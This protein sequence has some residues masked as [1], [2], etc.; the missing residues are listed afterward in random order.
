MSA[1]I[2]MERREILLPG[3]PSPTRLLHVPVR[4]DRRTI[5]TSRRKRESAHMET[6]ETELALR[7]DR[8]QLSRRG[9]IKTEQKT[10]IAI[11]P[12]PKPLQLNVRRRIHEQRREDLNAEIRI[13]QMAR[14][15]ETEQ[16]CHVRLDLERLRRT[17]HAEK[18]WLKRQTNS[19]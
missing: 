19:K 17:D 14:I 10:M 4:D 11:F 12:K 3:I 8:S 5:V 2:D 7:P 15:F 16:E 18:Y 1:E 9:A 13:R 6:S